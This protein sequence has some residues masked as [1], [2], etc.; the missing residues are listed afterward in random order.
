MEDTLGHEGGSL[1]YPA[2]G[3]IDFAQGTLEAW[4][5]PMFD[6]NVKLE[7]R[8]GQ[9]VYNNSFLQ[10]G[11]EGD[12]YACVY[13]NIADRGWRYVCYKRPKHEMVIPSKKTPWE[14]G[15][16]RHLAVTWGDAVRVYDN[17]NLV[18]DHPAQGLWNGRTPD[19]G[20][21][22]IRFGA[23][24]DDVSCFAV[25]DIR[26]SKVPLSPAEMLLEPSTRRRTDVTLL[27]DSLADIGPGTRK[28]EAAG[29]LHGGAAAEL[30]DGRGH[31]R[32]FTGD[33]RTQLN[34]LAADGCRTL[35][36]HSLWTPDYGKPYTVVNADRLDRLVAGC[37]RA[38]IKLL[39]Y[40]GSGLGD[41]APETSVY[42]DYWTSLPIIR[43]ASGDGDKRQAFSRSCTGCSHWTDFMLHH[44]RLSLL[45][46]NFDGFYYDGTIGFS[47]CLNASHGCSY[48]DAEGRRQPTYPLLATR[49]YAKRLYAISRQHRESNLIDCHTSA[50]VLP[51][52]AAWVDQLWNGEQFMSH[53]PGFHFPMD[54][55]RSQCVGTQY[56]VPS[57]FLSY[58]KRPFVESEA[59]SFTLLHDVLPRSR[60]TQVL[61]LWRI[62]DEFDVASARWIPYWRSGEYVQVTSDPPGRAWDEAGLASLYL[63]HGKRALLIVGNIQDDP[64]TVRVRLYASR[65]GLDTGMRARDAERQV[66]VPLDGNDMKLALQGY[67]YRVVWLE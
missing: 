64:A 23:R 43:W 6:P 40:V 29:V 48:T 15:Q 44:L 2:L 3:N 38:G 45:K 8:Q 42:H 51:V 62:Q 59:L 18:I 11:P 63:H 22:Q 21:L 37:H 7:T 1:T 56:G 19:L 58:H 46:H 67:D 34:K 20:S 16:W 30:S 24:G 17:G 39:L 10:V 60:S 31:V 12:Y 35:V 52:R 14:A 61:R 9:E 55:F 32:L 36:Y 26:V 4:V 47:A 65:L 5:K 33:A 53:K 50:N 49:R 28:T 25:K 57:M 13:W 41:L 27:L 66:P 54:Y